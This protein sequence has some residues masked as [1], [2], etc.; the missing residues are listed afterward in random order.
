M[1]FLFKFTRALHVVNFGQF[2]YLSRVRH[3]FKLKFREIVG[4]FKVNAL[5]AR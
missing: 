2:A 1:R 4:F 3:E 5:E